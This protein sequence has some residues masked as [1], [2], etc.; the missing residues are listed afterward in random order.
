MFSVPRRRR[1]ELHLFH[2][3][4]QSI[5]IDAS[6][7]ASSDCVRPAVRFVLQP[8]QDVLQGSVVDLVLLEQLLL[9]HRVGLGLELVDDR[10]LWCEN[11]KNNRDK[12]LEVVI[13]GSQCFRRFY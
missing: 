9:P 6:S 1:L 8:Q 11:M 4:R 2:G 7:L 12:G 13:I 3:P 10:F 5:A